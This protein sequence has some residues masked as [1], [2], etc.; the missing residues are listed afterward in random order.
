ML[1][2]SKTDIRK[3][4]LMTGQWNR[5]ITDRSRK[6]FEIKTDVNWL[7]VNDREYMLAESLKLLN[8]VLDHEDRI[9]KTRDY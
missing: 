3:V 6:K 5:F 4:D 2:M 9:D 8:R 1:M 7:T